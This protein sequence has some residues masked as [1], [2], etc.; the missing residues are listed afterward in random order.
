LF[1]VSHRAALALATVAGFFLTTYLIRVFVFPKTACWDCAGKGRKYPRW[2]SR[3]NF[4]D[5]A[6][7]GTSGKQVRFMRWFLGWL[8]NRPYSS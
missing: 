7:C 3:K 5:C 1:L 8:L 6:T 4:K 2:G